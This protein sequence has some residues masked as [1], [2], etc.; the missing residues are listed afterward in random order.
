MKNL[1]LVECGPRFEHSISR[2][3][4]ALV[5]EHLRRREPGMRILRRDL[6][7]VPPSFVDEAF[8][9]AM[10]IPPDRQSAS[11]R[12]ALAQSEILIGE[13]EATDVL[14]I[15]T[16]MHNFTVP[17]VLKA[18]IDQVLRIG[19]T[20]RSTPQGKQGLLADR[21]VYVVISSGGWIAGE[22]ARQP[23]FLTPYLAA[24]LATLGIRTIGFLYLEAMHGEADLP[25]RAEAH[26]RAWLDANLP[27][28]AEAA[29]QC[30]VR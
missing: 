23:D 16:P 14:V 30:F 18:W 6:A 27:L 7:C 1:L 12:A 15:A 21:P 25:L 9:Q 29:V 5:V 26:A 3:A 2:A 24:L 28:P 22:R 11:E 20:F 10:Y 8:T 19:R 4:A 13:L 17:A